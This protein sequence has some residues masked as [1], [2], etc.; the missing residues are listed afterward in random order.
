MYRKTRLHVTSTV[1]H[2]C[3]DSHEEVLHRAVLPDYDW[4][5]CKNLQ[6]SETFEVNAAMNMHIKVFA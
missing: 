4:Q 6:R 1:L 2:H 3:R 5:Y